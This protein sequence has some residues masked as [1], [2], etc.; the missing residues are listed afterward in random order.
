MMRNIMLSNEY[1]EKVKEA[2]EL[3]NEIEDVAKKMGTSLNT[4][5]EVYIKPD[6]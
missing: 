6:V 3:Y 4:A 1:S 5:L 2:K